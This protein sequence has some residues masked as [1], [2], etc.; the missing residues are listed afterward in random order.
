MSGVN[1][2]G[3]PIW[4]GLDF[5]NIRSIF[6]ASVWCASNRCGTVNKLDYYEKDICCWLGGGQSSF[7]AHAGGKLRPRTGIVSTI[8]PVLQFI[9]TVLTTV[10][11][12]WGTVPAFYEIVLLIAF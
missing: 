4:S 8:Y 10:F 12:K 1:G 3:R 7:S 2:G 5:S 6:E 11:L 9:T